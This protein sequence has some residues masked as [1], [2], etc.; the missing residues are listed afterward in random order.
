MKLFVFRSLPLDADSRTQRNMGLVYKELT[1][2]CTWEKDP[3]LANQDNAFNFPLSK[4]GNV[5]VR[6]IK[7]F[8][9]LFWVPYIVLTQS[10][11]SDVCIFMDLETV[12]FGGLAAKIKGSISV[13]DIVDPFAQTKRSLRKM[14]KL[15]DLI[16]CRFA[17]NA[18]ILMVPHE[19]RVQ[20]YHDM[21][22]KG[23]ISKEAFIVENVPNYSFVS[24]KSKEW[25]KQGHCVIGY[26][27]TLDYGSRGLEFLIS[28][29]KE[30]PDFISVV[31][32][33]QGAM[34]AELVNISV[35][36]ENIIFDGG[37][38]ADTLPELYNKVD[39]TW[40]YYCPAI[41]LHRYAAPNKY[42]EHLYF[43]TPIITSEIIPQF[44]MIEELNSGISIDV[45]VDSPSEVMRRL[46]DYLENR[47]TLESD[48]LSSYWQENYSEYYINKKVNFGRIL[49]DIQ[50]NL[51]AKKNSN[52]RVAIVGTVGVPACYGG[53][54]T[55]VENLLDENDY[56]FTVYC[57]SKAYTQKPRTYKKAQL[58]YIP[59]NANG[60]QS[61][62]Y[63]IWSLFHAVYKRADT[64]LVLGVSGAICLPFI[65]VFTKAKVITNIDGLEWRRDK[66]HVFAK[67]FLKFSERI[68]VKYSDVVVADNACIADYVMQ[69][70]GVEAV[71]I[72]YGGDH[73]IVKRSSMADDGYA[74]ALCRIEPENNVQMILDS[75]SKTKK[76]IKFIGN[77]SNSEFGQELKNKYQEYDNIEVIDPVYNLEKL[78]EIRQRCSF[79]VHG[80]SAGGTN[81]SLVEMMH[82]NKNI[83]TFDC[84][85][86]R[87]ST[88]GKANYFLT[89]ED[90]LRE[91]DQ[92]K[93]INNAFC[94]KEIALRRYTWEIV[95]KQYF[96]LFK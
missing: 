38:N 25:K 11:K 83:I 59:L 77:W 48:S 46:F 43:N 52:A 15:I 37:F 39:F 21:I 42:Y 66:W 93:L 23:V 4:S 50:G 58:H 84:D 91:I 87:A 5:I 51:N 86:N 36:H 24:D 49:T 47:S 12:L 44:K 57:S 8:L 54:E 72:A 29:A 33:G 81:P 56:L 79:Y 62:P 35:E 16:E 28:L 76:K 30:F 3:S 26:F 31:F 75:F 32:A 13:F 92:E 90:L 96:S 20:Y 65:R 45:S 82:F 85:Y 60:S 14:G 67:R 61:I 41:S 88:E 6:S 89:V 22:G 10:K 9:F 53:F 2:S 69:E 73:A 95:R 19:C 7:Y 64:I 34:E 78:F 18:D 63:D 70:Y 27:G 74:L 94:M 68:A 80:H 1:Y 55:L 71:V 17:R 40:A